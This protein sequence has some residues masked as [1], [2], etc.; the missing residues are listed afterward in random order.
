MSGLEEELRGL[1]GGG[2]C[3][4]AFAHALSGYG[5]ELRSFCHALLRDRASAD[6]AY[7][8]A[9]EDLWRGMP[10][11]R[12]DSSFRVWAYAVARHACLRELRGRRRALR[13]GTGYR[14]YLEAMGGSPRTE[15]KPCQRT[16]M[17]DRLRALRE[18]LDPDGQTL[19]TLRIDR[20][21]SFEQIARIMAGPSAE[22][23]SAEL[24][25]GAA[26]CRKRFERTK[27]RLRHLALEAGLIER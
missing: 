2:D 11:F 16:T 8:A 3:E 12:W 4:G 15:T 25:R 6:D 24:A 7:G 20:G 21:L 19:L 14:A 1:V 13:R 26:A 9:C 10:H 23:P 17:K 22:L 27:V 18:Q 5:F